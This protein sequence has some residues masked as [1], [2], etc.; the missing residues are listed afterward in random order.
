[1]SNEKVKDYVLNTITEESL[2]LFKQFEAN[3]KNPFSDKESVANYIVK[4]GDKLRSENGPAEGAP[5]RN[6]MPQT[7]AETLA[8][9]AK[10][11]TDV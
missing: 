3:G 6:V 2:N 4:N 8:V 10:G 5:R 1:M 7:D 9:A 11:M